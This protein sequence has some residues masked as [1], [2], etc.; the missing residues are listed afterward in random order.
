MMPTI[1]DKEKQA[2]LEGL[3]FFAKLRE[4]P[5]PIPVRVIPDKEMSDAQ[6]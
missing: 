4:D 3:K 5:K 6:G 2:R 1:T